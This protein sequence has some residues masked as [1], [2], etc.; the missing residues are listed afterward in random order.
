MPAQRQNWT[1]L[2]DYGITDNTALNLVSDSPM[3]ALALNLKPIDRGWAVTLTD[4]REL[5]RFIGLGAKRR[6]LRYLARM[7]LGRELRGVA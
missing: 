3:D 7:V 4:G 2:S 1:E 5:A 6:A